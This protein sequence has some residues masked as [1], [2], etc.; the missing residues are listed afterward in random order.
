METI[1]KAKQ[2][3]SL[4]MKH[5]QRAG[6]TLSKGQALDAIA[7]TRGLRD[8]NVLSAQLK[9]EQPVSAS[10]A[11]MLVKAEAHSD[12]RRVEVNFDA[13]AWFAQASDNDIRK[14]ANVGWGGD[15]DADAVADYFSSSA[16]SELY[17]YLYSKF[18]PKDVGFECN[19]DEISAM[20]WLAVHRPALAKELGGVDLSLVTSLR[21]LEVCMLDFFEYE[22]PD[23]VAE[24][25][26][27]Q[28]KAAFGHRGNGVDP[29]VWEYMVHVD[30]D[31]PVIDEVPV[32]LRPFFEQAVRQKTPWLMFHQG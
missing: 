1:K 10:M 3:A 24:W 13:S 32:T 8:W 6:I 2:E 9:V 29:G 5:L 17:E 22:T 21:V 7:A 26:W 14:L 30:L 27:V 23:E 16:T 31:H 28:Q 11:R 15:Y 18:V 4:L 12:D 19:V 25:A 20:T